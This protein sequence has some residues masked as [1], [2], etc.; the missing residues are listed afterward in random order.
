MI[1][2]EMDLFNSLMGM[3]FCRVNEWKDD[4]GTLFLR[5]IMLHSILSNKNVHSSAK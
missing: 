5:L 2:L 3:L 4:F 1:D